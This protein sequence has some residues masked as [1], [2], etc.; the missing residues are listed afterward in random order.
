MGVLCLRRPKGFTL[1]KPLSMAA[2][3]G[4]VSFE[5]LLN[6]NFENASN[7]WIFFIEIG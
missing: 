4:V 3:Y 5:N 2:R 1:W 7:G 6:A